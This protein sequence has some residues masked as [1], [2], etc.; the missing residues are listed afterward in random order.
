MYRA[1]LIN[2]SV[3]ACI[4]LDDDFLSMV[5][6]AWKFSSYAS[7]EDRVLACLV[8]DTRWEAGGLKE[9]SELN[10]VFVGL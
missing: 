5:L 3:Q 8:L 4:F 10:T 9:P 6:D 2:V 7:R 1:L